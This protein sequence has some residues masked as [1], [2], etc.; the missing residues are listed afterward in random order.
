MSASFP[1]IPDVDLRRAAGDGALARGRAYAK[2]GRVELLS[3][4]PN[5][6]SAIVRGSERYRVEV[7][8]QSGGLNGRC[9]CPAFEREAVCKHMVAV[10]LV[11][12]AAGPTD[13][14]ARLREHLLAQDVE[15]LADRLLRIAV[16]DDALRREI[17]REIADAA[18]DDDAVARRYRALIDE[19]TDPGDGVDYWGAGSYAEQI[20]SVIEPLRNLAGAGRAEVALE[21][22]DHL[23]DRIGEGS[24][25]TDDSEGEVFD[26]GQRAAAL[27]VELCRI[28]RPNPL[29]LAEALF[30]RE[31]DQVTDL[32]GDSDVV[33]ADVLGPDGVEAFRRLAREAWS[34]L[35]APKRGEF[36]STRGVLKAIL[37]RGAREIGDVDARIA[38]RTADLSTPFGYEEIA[39][40][41]LEAGRAEEALRWLDEGLWCFEG[42]QDERL[43]RKAAALMAAQ[44]RAGDAAA[45]LWKAFERNPGLGVF[46]ELAAL[47]QDEP[48]AAR[49][50]AFLRKAAEA[51]ARPGAWINAAAAALFDLQ[52]ELGAIDDA[53]TT[54]TTWGVGER[55]L[56]TLADRSRGSHRTYAAR[57]YGFLAESRI[58]DGGA[59]NYDLAVILIRLRGETCGDP[60]EQAAYVADIRLRHK[61]KRTF[62]QRLNGLG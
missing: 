58:A 32:F 50:T 51:Q 23:L 27:H 43:Q 42:R 14:L 45:L 53:W 6:A 46:R 20:E 4:G 44:G 35:P 49:A 40:I 29:V 57:T 62:I 60:A 24:S 10:A 11:A 1:L 33:Y 21:L 34:A 3:A 28:V 22:A 2:E 36:D 48:P 9:Q 25:E 47:A 56:R 13:R 16:R 8:P 59:A 30:E 7:L 55:R 18:E 61:A 54:A 41:C 39:D 31:M 19:A 38:L 37:D 15:A 26:V 5:G 52:L 12:S 17:E